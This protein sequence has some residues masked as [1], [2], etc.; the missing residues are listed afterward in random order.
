MEPGARTRDVY[1]PAGQWR[2]VLRGETF[3]GGQ[4][5]RGYPSPL[6]HLPWFKRL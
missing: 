4:W 5:L 6:D 2:A 3:E 1:L